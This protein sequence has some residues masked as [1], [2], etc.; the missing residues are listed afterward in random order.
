MFALG[1]GLC[2]FAFLGSFLL[3]KRSLAAGISFV[4]FWGY[5]Y[6]ILRANILTP[7]SHFIFDAALTGLYASRLFDK[8]PPGFKYR[9]GALSDWISVIA[10]WT[11]LIALIPFQTPMVTLVGLRGN[12]FFVPLL[13]LA[14][15][16][17]ESQFRIILCVLAMLNVCAFGFATAEYFLG[18]QRFYPLSPVTELIYRSRDAGGGNYRIP[19]IFSNAHSYAGTMVGT[20]PLLLSMTGLP[21]ASALQRILAILGSS[22]ALFG[23]L[24]ANTRTNFALAALIVIAFLFM[25]KMKIQWKALLTFLIL[26]VCLAALSNERF[27]RFRSLQNADEVTGR[28]AGSV[29]RSF[30]EVIT[31]YPLGNG[32]GGGGTSIP[33]FLEGQVRKAI[34]VENEYARIALELGIPGLIIWV[35]FLGWT[36]ARAKHFDKRDPWRSARIIQFFYYIITYLQ[37]SLG[38]GMLTSIPGTAMSMV[39][40]AWLVT[41]PEW[42]DPDGLASQAPNSISTETSGQ[43]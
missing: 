38:T 33:H 4:L 17:Q 42:E 10:V 2:C 27:Q 30:Y 25:G 8:L 21:N 23:V 34:G 39:F 32:L 29:N 13:L 26:G 36:L 37:S 28:I 20:L 9:T 15:R 3:G 19:G 14:A 40:L 18:I 6:G 35:S 22:S 5:F 31:E 11:L 24:Y 12:F 1:V 43:I 16:L 7:A 41:R